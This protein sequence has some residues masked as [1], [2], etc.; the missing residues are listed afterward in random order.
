MQEK[1]KVIIELLTKKTKSRLIDWT[2]QSEC[3]Y[4][5]DFEGA[6]ILL[7][8]QVSPSKDKKITT[9][10]IYNDKREVIAS[11][12]EDENKDIRELYKLAKY[13]YYHYNETLDTII[14]QLT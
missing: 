10:L 12:D 7:Y 14:K 8:Y 4:S 2:K 11:I 6:K 1:I 3:V 5:V 9:L 13:N